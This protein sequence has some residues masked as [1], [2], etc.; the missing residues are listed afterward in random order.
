MNTLDM[1]IYM[2]NRR[3]KN[4][5]YAL[6]RLGNACNKCGKKD[7]LQFD[8]IDRRSKN[9][10]LADMFSHSIENIDK[11]LDKCQLLCVECH[12]IKTFSDLNY[13]HHGTLRGYKNRKCR[14]QECVK[15]WSSYKIVY[16]A[17]RSEIRK[18]KK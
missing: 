3:S 15:A 13:K 18:L 1:K 2:Q 8:H 11:E 4:K 9:M 6:D 16:N 12:K 14:C 17:R 7:K 5:Q 10:I